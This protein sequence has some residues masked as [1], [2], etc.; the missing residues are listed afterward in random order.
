MISNSSL[1]DIGR[2][3]ME[4]E[5]ILLFP[6]T[7]PDG[8][9]IGSCAAL[10]RALREAGKT[11][12]ILL[13]EPVTG[14]LAFMDTEF[15]TEDKDIIG[16]PDVC[17]CIDC[18]EESRF[19]DRAAKY[20]EGR[21]KLCLD[22]HVTSGSFGDY[23]YV[24]GDEAATAQIV[25]RLLVEM[26]LEIGKT[27]AESLYIGISTDTGSFR[28]SNT[29]A[30]S[31]LIAAQLFK[32]GIDHTRI[33]VNLYNSVSYKRVR[34]ESEI[35]SRM[36]LLAEGKA[37]ISCVTEEMLAAE[38]ATLEDCEGVVDA[39]R[40]I[41]GVELAAFLKEKS[42]AVKVSLRAKSYGNVD[43]IAVKFGGGGHVKAAGCTL[44]MSMDEAMEVMKK[45]LCDYWER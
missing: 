4:A 12:W 14:Y 1:K 30:E 38:N 22:H 45:E 39:L 8:D 18:S 13:D 31:H 19:P 23:Y 3:L 40:D 17:V 28:H 36:E 2:M 33:I 35:L 41:R 44:Y 6:H 37:A 43:E 15:C 9:A 16:K 7:S 34:M 21:I 29:T 27:T 26:G 20:R 42:G 24:D 25:Y 5:T 10:C 11:V 32:K